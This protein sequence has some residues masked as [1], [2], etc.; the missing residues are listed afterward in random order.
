MHGMQEAKGSTPLSSTMESNKPYLVFLIF[1]GIAF[2][3]FMWSIHG[4]RVEKFTKE[5]AR[6]REVHVVW[7]WNRVAAWS[8][9][10][11]PGKGKLEERQE[12]VQKAVE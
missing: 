4:L 12:A 8:A 9:Q 6:W 10:I 7:D 3:F 11:R 1:L 5:G 2:G